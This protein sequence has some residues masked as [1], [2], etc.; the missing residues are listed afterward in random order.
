MKIKRGQRVSRLTGARICGIFVPDKAI[1]TLWEVHRLSKVLSDLAK[2][3]RITNPENRLNWLK[4]GGE[5][6]AHRKPGQLYRWSITKDKGK[7]TVQMTNLR[8]T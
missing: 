6:E 7:D 1:G 4:R 8:P 2:S 3:F 5:E